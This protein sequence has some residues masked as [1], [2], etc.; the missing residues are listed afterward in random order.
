LLDRPVRV[1]DDEGGWAETDLVG[2]APAAEKQFDD[3]LEETDAYAGPR[4]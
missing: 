2:P 4:R 1:N 3:R